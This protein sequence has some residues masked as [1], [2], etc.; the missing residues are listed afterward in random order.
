A[1]RAA[2]RRAMERAA[3]P[4]RLTAERPPLVAV[5]A[6]LTKAVPDGSWL[7]SLNIAGQELAIAGLS[8]SA[9]GV[10]LALEASHRFAN[11]RFRAPIM[12]EPQTG[13]ERFQLSAT[14]AEP[15]R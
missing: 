14:L 3:E 6:D 12:R 15:A 7:K 9:A 11:V 4:L 10:A 8:P 5:L 2:A 13:L 1:A